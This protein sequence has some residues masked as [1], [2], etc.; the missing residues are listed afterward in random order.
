M[1]L[2]LRSSSRVSRPLRAAI[3]LLSFAAAVLGGC[4]QAPPRGLVS[5]ADL[6]PPPPAP[7]LTR[8]SGS[9][10]ERGV[11]DQRSDRSE[12]IDMGD[13]SA[14]EAGVGPVDQ[15]PALPDF[16]PVEEVPEEGIPSAGVTGV[17]SSGGKS[18][19]FW[20]EGPRLWRR[21]VGRDHR[22]T[23]PGEIVAELDV[24]G[25]L[26]RD[27]GADAE[28]PG[29]EPEG[30]EAE[31]SGAARDD[32]GTSGDL[33][34]LAAPGA[35]LAFVAT[36]LVGELPWVAY[37]ASDGPSYL[38]AADFPQEAQTRI[39]LPFR[40]VVRLT[41]VDGRLLVVGRLDGGAL[42]WLFVDGLA[43][44]PLIEDPIGLTLPDDLTT[45][46]GSAVLR[47]NTAGQ[48]VYLDRAGALVG[49]APCVSA[50]GVFFGN[51]ER[52][53]LS[54]QRLSARAA[55]LNVASLLKAD[56]DFAYGVLRLVGGEVLD[57]PNDNGTRSVVGLTFAQEGTAQRLILLSADGLR[58][59]SESWVSWPFE[60]ARAVLDRGDV[61]L[62]VNF[63]EDA[64]P[65]LERLAL[66]ANLFEGDE[67]FGIELDPR[68]RPTLERCDWVDQNCDGLEDNGLCCAVGYFEN[69]HDFTVSRDP[70]T[71]LEFLISDVENLDA[72]RVAIRVGEAQWQIWFLLYR[73]AF[74]GSSQL[75][76]KGEIQGAHEGFGLVSAGG[77]SALIAR[78]GEGRWTSFWHYDGL[79]SERKEPEPLRCARPLALDLVGDSPTATA[80]VLICSDRLIQLRSDR[81]PETRVFEA[82]REI[83][84]LH[85]SIEE[86]EW[87]TI[88]RH[89]G[90]QSSTVYGYRASDDG[91]WQIRKTIL[92]FSA[93]EEIVAR[94][95]DSLSVPLNLSEADS[96]FPIFGHQSALAPA[97]PLLQLRGSAARP[98]PYLLLPFENGYSWQ[99]VVT[100]KD[101][102]GAQYARLIR[103][104]VTAGPLESGAPGEREVTGFWVID[105]PE[106]GTRINLWSTLPAFSWEGPAPH[107]ALLQGSYSD[108]IVLLGE[109]AADPDR[110]RWKIATRQV[111]RCSF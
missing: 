88:T 85:D 65:R 98:E 12:A 35:P 70:D 96:A 108:Y 18:W 82:N 95:R 62:V 56:D 105:L 109:D 75:L 6:A 13:R 25:Q 73:N 81:N 60:G 16:A 37:G 2:S 32:L 1:A 14:E 52:P 10:P 106:D 27:E 55:E 21:V 57:F 49:N 39:E 101:L 59:S 110:R 8:D 63:R 100:S 71:P 94:G 69:E 3:V 78:D 87:A 107:W 9:A 90:G 43:L 54:Y 51:A 36:A 19:V 53:M 7:P 99:R 40:G 34:G 48:C 111:T 38:L 83:G 28:T 26:M 11:A 23:G 66:E 42:G 104:F 41:G 91:R 68:C 80:P 24:A 29:E 92:S 103:K 86:I 50:N 47:Y 46:G 72:A 33:G 22:F 30:D 17:L 61:A 102:T 4:E 89:G 15:G 5:R 31:D 97:P 20:G 44:T 64:P 67:P 76:Y 79:A 58:Q 93:G 45:L 84:G 77:R 74:R